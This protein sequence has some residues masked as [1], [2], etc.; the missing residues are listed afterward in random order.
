M[1]K[2]CRKMTDELKEDKNKQ[3]ELQKIMKITNKKLNKETEVLK[4]TK[5][6][7]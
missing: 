5:K 6:A 1:D 3:S 4:T 2:E 7:Q